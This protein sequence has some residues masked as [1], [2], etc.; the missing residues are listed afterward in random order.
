MTKIE[1]VKVLSLWDDVKRELAFLLPFFVLG[2]ILCLVCEV[3]QG[4]A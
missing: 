4:R 1:P 2:V 3:S